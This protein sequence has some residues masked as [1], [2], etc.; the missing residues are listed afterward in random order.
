MT[1]TELAECIVRGNTSATHLP[2]P[3][4]DRNDVFFLAT[5]GAKGEELAPRLYHEHGP[6]GYFYYRMATLFNIPR[7]LAEEV[8]QMARRGLDPLAI[9]QHVRAW[10]DPYHH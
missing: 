9:A 10:K 7:Y 5:V 4:S 6:P 2:V 1:P 3:D 8:A